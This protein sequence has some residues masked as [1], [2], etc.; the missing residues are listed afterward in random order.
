[1][2]D[3]QNNGLER[4]QRSI[5]ELQETYE[6]AH[7]EIKNTTTNIEQRM[8][9]IQVDQSK[10]KLAQ[11]ILEKSQEINENTMTTIREEQRT[12]IQQIQEQ[13]NALGSMEKEL[14]KTK[15]DN[16]TSKYDQN[17]CLRNQSDKIKCMENAY[18]I[19][20]I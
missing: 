16:S 1:M 4:I 11:D 12:T 6:Q 14:Q 3:E 2:L 8:S 20:K 19:W 9:L 13:S 10:I 15:I 5:Q 17:Q 7:A 18:R